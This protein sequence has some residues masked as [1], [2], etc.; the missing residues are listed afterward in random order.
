MPSKMPSGKRKA[1]R[2]DTDFTQYA[3]GGKVGL[4]KEGAKHA[5]DL[6]G[7]TPESLEAWRVAN[8]KPF[9]QQQNPVV[10]QAVDAYRRGDINQNQMIVRPARNQVKPV[11]HQFFRKRPPVRET[12]WRQSLALP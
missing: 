2:D 12:Y 4:L 7:I 1:R 6:L 10:A 8:K 3:E 11:L 9:K 5:F